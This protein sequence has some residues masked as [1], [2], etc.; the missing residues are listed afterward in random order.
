MSIFNIASNKL[1]Y[2]YDS[3]RVSKLT[4][5]I[6]RFSMDFENKN[7]LVIYRLG[8]KKLLNKMNISKF[9]RCYFDKLSNFDQLRLVKFTVFQQLLK[10]LFSGNSCSTV[11]FIELIQEEMNN[12]CIF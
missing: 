2:L 1:H 7:I 12:A 6:E 5:K 10:N 9:E 11:A 3:L 8:R 4:A